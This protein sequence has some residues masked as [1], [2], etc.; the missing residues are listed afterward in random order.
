MRACRAGARG[1]CVRGEAPSPSEERWK[2]HCPQSGLWM[3]LGECDSLSSC[4]PASLLPLRIPPLSFSLS[5]PFLRSFLLFS[6]FLFFPSFLPSSG[7]GF[8]A[9]S[10]APG[11]AGEEAGGGAERGGAAP[12]RARRLRMGAGLARPHGPLPLPPPPRRRNL[13]QRRPMPPGAAAPGQ[14]NT[15]VAVAAAG[16]PA[17][18]APRPALARAAPRPAPGRAQLAL[19][20]RG[21]PPGL[22]R[23]AGVLGG[24]LW[25]VGF[26]V[27]QSERAAAAAAAGGGRGSSGGGVLR[28]GGPREGRREG[29]TGVRGRG[30]ALGQLRS[31]PPEPASLFCLLPSAASGF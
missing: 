18:S 3:L 6:S 27:L 10:A 15:T 14:E 28:E 9:R 22:G 25:E 5:L 23:R 12:S 19:A 30:S 2:Q 8:P 29:G 21:G 16:A 24:G 31:R 13:S 17:A 11:Q 20:K 4:F 1:D 26:I 7:P